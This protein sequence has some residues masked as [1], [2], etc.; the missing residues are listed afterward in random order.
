MEQ[1]PSTLIL[2]LRKLPWIRRRI[3]YRSFAEKEFSLTNELE[4]KRAFA[5]L[6]MNKDG[7]I[8]AGDFAM[9]YKLMCLDEK[10]TQKLDV[11][12]L[13]RVFDMNHDLKISFE[14]FV[15]T[16]IVK[17]ETLMTQNDIK[18]IFKRC[19]LRSKGYITIGD[20]IQVMASFG[21]ELQVENARLML[22]EADL[23]FNGRIELNE[24]NRIMRI[25]RK[26]I[27]FCVGIIIATCETEEL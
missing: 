22:R 6:D 23:N 16:M 14:E 26:D 25:M 10:Q 9:M 19:D 21:K 3:I 4:F 17:M 1:I 13:V 8:S 11:N 20:I 2:Y 12:R 5:F 24:F 15:A 7:F 27:L 18:H